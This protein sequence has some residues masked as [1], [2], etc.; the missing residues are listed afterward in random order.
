MIKQI[1]IFI[2]IIYYDDLETRQSNKHS[3]FQIFFQKKMVH[4]PSFHLLFTRTFSLITYSD[5]LS[6]CKYFDTAMQ[7][8]KCLHKQKC[9]HDFIS[10]KRFWNCYSEEGW[11]K[12][13]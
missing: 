3:S 10:R 2:I 13:S 7:F 11:N 8:K 9:I 1:Y 4:Q 12:C 6:Q 5:F